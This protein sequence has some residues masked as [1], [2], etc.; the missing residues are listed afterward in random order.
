MYVEACTVSW[1]MVHNYLPH[2]HKR[3][4][5]ANGQPTKDLTSPGN[6]GRE[7]NN[8]HIPTTFLDTYIEAQPP[9]P[10]GKV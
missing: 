4:G 3:G 8:L 10:V 5:R 7:G 6:A 2:S 9:L 1:I